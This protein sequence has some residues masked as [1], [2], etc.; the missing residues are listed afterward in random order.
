MKK[1]SLI[2]GVLFCLVL[3]ISCKDVE[4]LIEIE[5][6]VTSVNDEQ[7][8][9]IGSTEGLIEPKQKDFKIYEFNFNMEHTEAVKDRKIEMYK[10]EI[11]RQ[12]FNE[13]DGITRYWNGSEYSQ[14][15]EGENFVTYHHEVVFYAKDLS[16]DEIRKALGN[17]KIIVSWTDITKEQS[18]KEYVLSDLIKIN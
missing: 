5:A 11:L 17:E 1:L 12:V 13:I 9:K 3:L 2:F 7:Y 15:N 8:R 4:P 18:E 6:K 14:D 10:F 16:D